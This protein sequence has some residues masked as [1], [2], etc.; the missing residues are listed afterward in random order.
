MLVSAHLEDVVR[1]ATSWGL[2]AE[3]A[4]RHLDDVLARLNAALAGGAARDDQRVTEL[5]ASRLA[6]LTRP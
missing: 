4:R 6:R 2:G 5:V 3:P 1:E